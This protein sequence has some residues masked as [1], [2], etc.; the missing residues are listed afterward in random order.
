MHD[1]WIMHIIIRRVEK[2]MCENMDVIWLSK[3]T[4]NIAN[5]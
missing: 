4:T 3:Y 5:F 1:G 2:Y